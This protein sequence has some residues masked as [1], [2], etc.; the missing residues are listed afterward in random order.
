MVMQHFVGKEL[1][2]KLSICLISLTTQHM[3]L[4]ILLLT[5]RLD[6]LLTQDIQDHL[7]IVLVS[8]SRKI[9]PAL[10]S[11]NRIMIGLCMYR[12]FTY[13][14]YV[15]LEMYFVQINFPT[16]VALECIETVIKKICFLSC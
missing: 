16:D 11:A 2:M 5:T 4:F 1:Y 3:E 13:K 9:L 7:H 8:D 14:V 15:L 12:S 6:L 10:A